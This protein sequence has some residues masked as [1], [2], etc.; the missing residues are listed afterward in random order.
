MNQTDRVVGS[1]L[2]CADTICVAIG[3][4]AG[5]KGT[6]IREALHWCTEWTLAGIQPLQPFNLLTILSFSRSLC[7]SAFFVFLYIFF[8]LRQLRLQ[9]SAPSS[10]NNNN[11][12]DINIASKGSTLKKKKNSNDDLV[13]IHR[14]VCT[15]ASAV[16]NNNIRAL[17][18]TNQKQVAYVAR[19][20]EVPHVLDVFVCQLLTLPFVPSQ[21]VSALL[22]V[23][24]NYSIL[25]HFTIQ[26]QMSVLTYCWRLI[27]PHNSTTS[28]TVA[29]LI[30]VWWIYTSIFICT[31]GIHAFSFW[32]S[33]CDMQCSDWSRLFVVCLFV[34][35]CPWS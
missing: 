5:R 32:F 25:Q 33:I 21:T 4:W 10:T 35:F 12:N 24:C 1:V 13:S 11:N 3:R 14:L 9:H 29:E 18:N 34:F 28:N 8:L 30:K 16:M 20:A 27:S 19:F 22:S 6:R 23:V 26:E 17:Y 31:Y 15:F 2:W 7:L